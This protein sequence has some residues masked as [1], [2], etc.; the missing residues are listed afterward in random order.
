MNIHQK[1]NQKSWLGFYPDKEPIDRPLM[2][3]GYSD[4][5][6]HNRLVPFQEMPKKRRRFPNIG[7]FADLF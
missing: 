2:K 7:L 1:I 3:F 6:I 4:G 5:L